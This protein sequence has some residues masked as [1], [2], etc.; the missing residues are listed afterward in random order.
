M[1]VLLGSG[2]FNQGTVRGDRP[3]TGVGT[4]LVSEF[5]GLLGVRVGVK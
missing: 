5:E 1:E 4:V 2:G 3:E